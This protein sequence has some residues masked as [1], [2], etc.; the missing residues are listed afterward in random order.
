MSNDTTPIQTG[1]KKS[2][3]AKEDAWYLPDGIHNGVIT[4]EKLQNDGIHNDNIELLITCPYN[5]RNK[6]LTC[7]IPLKE[8]AILYCDVLTLLGRKENELYEG[9]LLNKKISI[10]AKNSPHP[11]SKEYNKTQIE[12]IYAE[13][14]SEKISIRS[15][16]KNEAPFAI[17]SNTNDEDPFL[18]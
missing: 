1:A 5:G 18:K 14:K 4:S 12:H 13:K 8:N 10:K 16:V 7:W 6:E 15:D 9:E 11:V 17:P 2:Y 3:V